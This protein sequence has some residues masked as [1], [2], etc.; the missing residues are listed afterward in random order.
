[1][2]PHIVSSATIHPATGINR[3]IDENTSRA[4]SRRVVMATRHVG[5]TIIE[6][7][8]VA[9]IVL[10]G[11][12]TLFL[13]ILASI[14]SLGVF[15][16]LLTSMIIPFTDNW[17][18]YKNMRIWRIVII[19]YGAVIAIYTLFIIIYGIGFEGAPVWHDASAYFFFLI[20]A[21]ELVV[22]VIISLI[23][24]FVLIPMLANASR[25]YRATSDAANARLRRSNALHVAGSYN[26]MFTPRIVSSNIKGSRKKKRRRRRN[27]YMV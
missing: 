25:N 21:L 20:I 8:I 22:V 17:L 15:F 3:I 10:T 18:N 2:L 27:E 23:V 11:L 26:R 7:I 9:M 4:I 6:I 12:V 5:F 14:D 16:M 24:A 1:M 13:P 19:V